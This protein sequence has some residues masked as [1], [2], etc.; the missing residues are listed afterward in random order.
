MNEL[1]IKSK[2]QLGAGTE[3]TVFPYERFQDKV[4]K[5]KTRNITFQGSTIKQI[6]GGSLNMEEMEIFKNYPE[7]FAHVYK[8]TNR[9]AIIE[10]LDTASIEKDLDNLATGLIKYFIDNPERAN[11]FTLKD[12][13][14]LT[15]Q[16]FSV[17]ADIYQNLRDPDFLKGLFDYAPDKKF[18]KKLITFIANVY[19]LKNELKRGIDVHNGNLGYD[20]DKN[21]KLLDI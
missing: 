15:S 2:T 7:F 19:K 12:P 8:L 9:Y 21:I 5:T 17:S 1:N 6:P 18:C 11:F 4:I 16:D 10:K 20:K 14:L 13:S 3:H